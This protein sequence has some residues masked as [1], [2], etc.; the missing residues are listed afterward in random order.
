MG[1]Q[2]QLLLQPTEV[3]MGLQ[4]GVEFD[5]NSVVALDIIPGAR[6]DCVLEWCMWC[7]GPPL[8]KLLFRLLHQHKDWIKNNPYR[9][10][11]YYT[12]Q[13]PSKSYYS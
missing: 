12:Q 6:I 3:E 10:L 13:E 2:S 1:K 4:V 7:S 11:G 5:N 8:S 9:V